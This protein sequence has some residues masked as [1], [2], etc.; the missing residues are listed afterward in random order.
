[1]VVAYLAAILIYKEKY[2]LYQKLGVLA[3]ALAVVL[4]AI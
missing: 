2:T 3:G 1:M 4:L